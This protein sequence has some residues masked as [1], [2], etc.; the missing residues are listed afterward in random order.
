MGRGWALNSKLWAI[1]LGVQLA[2][3]R[4]FT[5]LIV[6][7]DCSVVVGMIKDCLAGTHSETSVRQI[8]EIVRHLEGFKIQVFKREW[9]A[10]ADFLVKTCATNAGTLRII[11]FPNDHVRQLLHADLAAV[12]I[13]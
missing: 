12:S 1:L 4:G 7:S 9:N 6:E 8:K 3:S 2:R 10:V 11:D 13:V 5:K